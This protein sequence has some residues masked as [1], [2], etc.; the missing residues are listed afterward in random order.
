MA[1]TVMTMKVFQST[2]IK[3]L[4]RQRPF[5]YLNRIALRHKAIEHLLDQ[6]KKYNDIR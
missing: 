2:F 5:M 4:E 1:T 6:H 3:P